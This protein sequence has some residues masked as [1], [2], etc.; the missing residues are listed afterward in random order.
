ML[1]LDGK[2]LGP[3]HEMGGDKILRVLD[4]LGARQFVNEIYG[5]AGAD[6]L[7][8]DSGRALDEGVRA[9]EEKADQKKLMKPAIALVHVGHRGAMRN[10]A[11]AATKAR[12]ETREISRPAGMSLQGWHALRRSTPLRHAPRGLRRARK[13]HRR[14]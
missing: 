3:G 11:P 12:P 5:A 1:S 13:T 14:I 6:Q 7:K 9:L 8:R 4:Q 2:A 10:H